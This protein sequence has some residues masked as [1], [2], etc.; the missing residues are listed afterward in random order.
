MVRW[1]ASVRVTVAWRLSPGTC[2]TATWPL[3]RSRSTMP[4]TAGSSI[5]VTSTIWPMV[6]PGWSRTAHSTTNC[7]APSWLAGTTA[8]KM[9]VCR[10]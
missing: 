4:R 5:A 1:P 10:W 7:A 2:S 8:W 3:Q 6:A 9:A